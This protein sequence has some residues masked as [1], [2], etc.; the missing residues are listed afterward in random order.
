MTWFIL[1]L[2]MF[3][4][5]INIS[6]NVEVLSDEDL[7]FNDQE[8]VVE[9]I[10]EILLGN[11]D[12]FDEYNDIDSEEQSLKKHSNFQLHLNSFFSSAHFLVSDFAFSS[13]SAFSYNRLIH[14]GVSFLN[15]P[16]PQ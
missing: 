2:H 8:S 13:D 5:S 6:D 3:N 16:P 11:T 9:F 4:C 12:A 10:I 15:N 1:G 7:A 14:E